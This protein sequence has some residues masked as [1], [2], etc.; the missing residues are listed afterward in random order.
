MSSAFGVLYMY[1]LGVRGWG[2]GAMFPSPRHDKLVSC[3]FML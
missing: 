1:L 3:L 2:G